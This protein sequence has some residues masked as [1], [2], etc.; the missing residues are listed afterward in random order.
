MTVARTITASLG[1]RWHGSYGMVRCPAHDDRTPS[2]SIRDGEAG[3]LLVHCHAGCEGAAVLRLLRDRGLL[4]DDDRSRHPVPTPIVTAAEEEAERTAAAE[5]IWKA[6][7]PIEGTPAAAYLLARGIALQAP[8]TLRYAPQ[9]RYDRDTALPALIAAVQAPDRRVTAV[10]RIW[11]DP[12]GDR[13]ASVP[14][15]KKTL[16]PIR[17]SAV[18]LAPAAETLALVEG[19]ED[20]LSLMQMT[21]QSAWA[22]LGTSNFRNFVPPEGVRTLVLAPDADGAGDRAVSEA[23]ARFAMMGLRVLHL[24]PPEGQDWCDTLADFEERA[25]I[26]QYDGGLSRTEAELAAFA[27]IVGGEVRHAA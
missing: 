7:G 5:A 4:A 15:P 27:E 6:A 12:C 18:R 19:V 10:Q 20:G 23:A 17:G 25:A 8:P 24:R 16:G 2:L 21:G 26:G 22:L 13:K 1:G 14:A 3:R 9:L 11:I